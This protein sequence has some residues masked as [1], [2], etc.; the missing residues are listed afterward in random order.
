M[1]ARVVP[2]RVAAAASRRPHSS[3]WS[4][5]SSQA[6]LELSGGSTVRRLSL[7]QSSCYSSG[8]HTWERELRKDKYILIKMFESVWQRKLV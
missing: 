6:D 2:A 3:F 8:S 5:K 1:V 4:D 7:I